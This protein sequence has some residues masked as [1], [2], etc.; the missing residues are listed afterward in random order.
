MNRKIIGRSG[1]RGRAPS[2]RQAGDNGHLSTA[3]PVYEGMFSFNHIVTTVAQK[4]LCHS[5]VP[6]CS[7]E[8]DLTALPEVSPWGTL[9]GLHRDHHRPVLY[10]LLRG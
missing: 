10:R 4:S 9:S 3:L 6:Q 5:L 7:L 8:Q 2:H 1:T